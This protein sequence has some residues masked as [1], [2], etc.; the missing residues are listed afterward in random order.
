MT[1]LDPIIRGVIIEK[2]E[3]LTLD[4]FSRAI[5]V[6]TELIVEMVEHELLQPEGKSYTDWRFDS[7]SIKRARIASSF[8]YDLEVNMQGVALALELLDKIDNLQYRVDLF[9]KGIK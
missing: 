5:H 1:D 3:S 2:S 8:Y 9:E 4:E 6:K 7:V